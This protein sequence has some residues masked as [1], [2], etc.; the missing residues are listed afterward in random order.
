MNKRFASAFV[1][2]TGIL[3]LLWVKP[4]SS[5]AQEAKSK[6]VHIEMASSAGKNFIATTDSSVKDLHIPTSEL[7]L[8]VK[9]L[10]LEELSVDVN[11]WFNTLKSKV[12]EIT[13]AEIELKRQDGSLD[14]TKL[15]E[16]ISSL[17]EEQAALINRLNIVLDEIIKKGGNPTT[18]QKYIAAISGVD[19]NL[20]IAKRGNISLRLSNWLK[21]DE[22]G[23]RWGFNILKFVI[24]VSSSFA[25]S[26]IT[27]KLVKT[28]LNRFSN[29]SNLFL[30]FLVISSERGVIVIGILIGLTSLGISIGPLLALIGGVSFVLGFALQ[31][32]LGNFASGLMLLVYKPFD[33]GDR[34]LIPGTSDQGFVKTITLANTSFDHYT[35]KIVTLPNS[36]VWGSRIE[37]LLPGDHRLIELL[38]MISSNDDIRRIKDAWESAT[39]SNPDIVKDKWSMSLPYI[40]PKSGDL[41]YWCGAW[42]SK[43]NYWEVYVNVVMSIW[44]NLKDSGIAFGL[45]KGESYVH[46][47][48]EQM[49]FLNEKNQVIEETKSNP[50]TFMEPDAIE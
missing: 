6:D 47:T 48:N 2:S 18:Y 11:A 50:R 45:N 22:G 23:I 25:V 19:L 30:D 16:N 7:S 4:T 35:G 8:L 20:D 29:I 41:M 17:Q 44:D 15:V 28:S 43:D 31:N 9:P 34:V 26:R 21:S 13:K 40:S 39:A 27:K 12:D 37:N 1:L 5:L 32:N 3:T 38:F 33:V 24:I 36:E 42:A 10:T 14:T 46:L 49:K